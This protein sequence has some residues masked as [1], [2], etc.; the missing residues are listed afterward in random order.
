MVRELEATAVGDRAA[1]HT[2][3]A[4]TSHGHGRP[5]WMVWVLAAHGERPQRPLDATLKLGLR[6]RLRRIRRLAGWTRGK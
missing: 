2:I 3:V 1:R 4:A 6:A 5:L